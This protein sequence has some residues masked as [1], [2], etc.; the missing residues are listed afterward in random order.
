TPSIT[1]DGG[2]VASIWSRRRAGAST[3]QYS[4]S[5]VVSAEGGEVP[6]PF[7]GAGALAAASAPASGVWQMSAGQ[8]LKFWLAPLWI[9]MAYRK[10]SSS[11]ST[12]T[13]EPPRAG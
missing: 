9:R 4:K 11:A 2:V 3:G 13:I 8:R 10:R 1:H 7:A 6:A 12:R 5:S